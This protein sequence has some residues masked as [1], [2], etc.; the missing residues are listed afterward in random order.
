MRGKYRICKFSQSCDEPSLNKTCLHTNRETDLMPKTTLRRIYYSKKISMKTAY[1]VLYTTRHVYRTLTL[2]NKKKVSQ[3]ENYTSTKNIRKVQSKDRSNIQQ[4]LIQPS[5]KRKEDKSN[6][7]KRIWYVYYR[8]TW[9]TMYLCELTSRLKRKS[10]L[11]W[12]CQIV[13]S[14]GTS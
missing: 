4:I 10:N 11:Y 12:G 9:A 1:T 6:W 5:Y 14:A 13:Q 3:P 2:L 7:S 8:V